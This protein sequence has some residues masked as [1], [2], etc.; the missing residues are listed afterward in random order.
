MTNLTNEIHIYFFAVLNVSIDFK[1]K[2]IEWMDEE[3]G[4]RQVLNASKSFKENW[5]GIIVG[6]PFG[7]VKIKG[8]P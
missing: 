1:C 6:I 7:T 3:E 4:L 5:I 2:I 8:L